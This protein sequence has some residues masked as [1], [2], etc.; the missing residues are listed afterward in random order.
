MALV[1]THFFSTSCHSENWYGTMKKK[2]KID[3]RS[4]IMLQFISS[5]INFLEKL[6]LQIVLLNIAYT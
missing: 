4:K 2:K 5:R 1:S 6:S 3:T